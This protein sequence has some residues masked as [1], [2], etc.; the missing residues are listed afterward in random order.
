PP[1]R[2]IP[3][4]YSSQP[5]SRESSAPLSEKSLHTEPS[6]LPP[7]FS[8]I[9]A[10]NTLGRT[11][12]RK[13]VGPSVS[14]MIDTQP[15]KQI[16]FVAGDSAIDST[17]GTPVSIDASMS[18]G[19]S[20][21][22]MIVDSGNGMSKSLIEFSYVPSTQHIRFGELDPISVEEARR[23]SAQHERRLDT[24]Q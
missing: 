9:P 24:V 16:M 12:A 11:F 5:M 6:R 14:P 8:P 13:D 3:P 10:R 4:G 19:S 2:P 15:T 1:P 21:P 18:R 17:P 23:R 22:G 7:K 20:G